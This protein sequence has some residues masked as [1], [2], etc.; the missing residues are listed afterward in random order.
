MEVKAPPWN[1]YEQ[2]NT[3]R[4]VV[5]GPHDEFMCICG[6]YAS[7]AI[8]VSDREFEVLPD[9]PRSLNGTLYNLLYGTYCSQEC[10]ALE[11]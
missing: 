3:V 8:Y 9:E 7:T 1:Q 10:R 5:I 2:P 11:T 4:D 6:V